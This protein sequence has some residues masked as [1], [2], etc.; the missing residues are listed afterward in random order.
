[1]F[2][3]FLFIP[4]N[5]EKYIKKSE[6]LSNLDNRIFDLEDSILSIDFN[7]ALN[8]IYTVQ[9]RKTDWIRLPKEKYNDHEII[10]KLKEIGINNFVIPKFEGFDEFKSIYTELT[11]IYKEPR[12]I[13]LIENSNSYIDL[14]MILKEYNQNIHGVSLGIHDF[15]FNTG[16]YNDYKILKDIR[17]NIMLLA[18]SYSVVP[19]DVTSI[20]L[21]DER[22]LVEEII[23]GFNIGYRAKLLIHPNPS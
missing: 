11:K 15:C 9:L 23:D 19:I 20:Y 5:K 1:M 17:L 4:L 18:N 22:K 10:Q 21:T 2:S 3:S 7:K 16:I 13:L 8:N 12:M 6:S 14:E